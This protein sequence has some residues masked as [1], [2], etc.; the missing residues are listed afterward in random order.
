MPSFDTT[1]RALWGFIIL[2]LNFSGGLW[3][4]VSRVQEVAKRDTVSHYQFEAYTLASFRVEMDFE[5]ALVNNR[6]Q[7][8]ALRAKDIVAVDL[9]YSLF[10]ENKNFESLN[11]QRLA[12]LE[13]LFPSLLYKPNIEW[14]YV[15]QKRASNR[16]EAEGLF[17]GFVVY[18]K[19]LA[20]LSYLRKPPIKN[21]SEA[22]LSLEEKTAWK[23]LI[24]GKTADI[25]PQ[26]MP[27]L[28]RNMPKWLPDSC[29]FI[30]DWTASMYPFGL[31]V[32][33]WLDRYPRD[34]SQVKGLILFNDGDDR[35]LGEKV[36]GQTGGIYGTFKTDSDDLLQLM[37]KVK[38]QG[39]GG[40]DEENDLEAVLAASQRFANCQDLVLLVD[41]RSFVRD[42]PLLPQLKAQLESRQ[43][44]L[45]I[46]LCAAE[47]KIV[48]DYFVIAHN[49][50]AS[51]HSPNEDL[52]S[53]E[54]LKQEGGFEI[55]GKYY[56]L[57]KK[58]LHILPQKKQK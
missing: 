18:Y 7:L 26:V 23:A 14:R 20:T 3:A 4:Q 52:L 28:E 25:R 32:L 6:A 56:F 37:Q 43:Q 36:I 21:T 33:Q 29:A 57:D 17:H 54:Q 40:E 50:Q 11:A 10:P 42:L 31:E 45:H 5:G 39:Q 27:I 49:T 22:R 12:N 51:L 38:K 1:I 13:T 9:V 34:R 47:E 46:L 30:I 2:W 48:P 35:L 24:D 55:A 41:A 15:G 53:T 19:D 44:R 58:G 8:A 16:R